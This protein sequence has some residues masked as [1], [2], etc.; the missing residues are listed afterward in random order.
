MTEATEMKQRKARFSLATWAKENGYE[1]AIRALSLDD[2]DKLKAALI[3]LEKADA[4]FAL[5]TDRR[6][7]A[8]YAVQCWHAQ[9]GQ[10]RAAAAGSQV[11]QD[12]AKG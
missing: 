4:A 10:I 8:D 6:Q 5:W 12:R 7:E 9:L 3:A 11:E 1:R 2:C